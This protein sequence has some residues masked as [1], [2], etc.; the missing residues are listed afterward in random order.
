MQITRRRSRDVCAP[1]SRAR[2][3]RTFFKQLLVFLGVG[4]SISFA[5]AATEYYVAPNGSPSGDGSM[6][7]P[8]DLQ[9]ML[10]YSSPVHPGDTI[11]LRGGTYAG[12][13]TSHINGTASSPIVVRQYPG[14]R[15]T[16]D[17][18]SIG[19]TAMLTVGGSYTWFWGFEIMSSNAHRVSTQ[20]GS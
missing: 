17:G 4:L 19:G 14:E 15:A 2:T 3:H 1:V 8:K 13:F 7:N 11:W 10:G 16:I 12:T 20:T 5:A 9:T 18:G 6:A